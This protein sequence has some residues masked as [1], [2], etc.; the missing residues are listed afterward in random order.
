[1]SHKAILRALIADRLTRR[2]SPMLVRRLLA[3]KV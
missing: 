2:A 3:A 1:M